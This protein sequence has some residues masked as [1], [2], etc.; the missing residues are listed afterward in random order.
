MSK[1]GK[2]VLFYIRNNK[3]SSLF[4]HNF[5]LI[6]I[7]V[8]LPAGLLCGAVFLYFRHAYLQEVDESAQN[9]LLQVQVS[10][11]ANQRNM[12]ALGRNMAN[13]SEISSFLAS[14]Y[15]NG[16]TFEE[17]QLLK[18]IWDDISRMKSEYVEE[19]AVFSMSNGYVIIG[20]G[21][22]MKQEYL[23]DAPDL[24]MVSN[25]LEDIS[26][27]TW[28]RVK[29]GAVGSNKGFLSTSIRVPLSQRGEIEGCIVLDMSGNWI[30]R[31]AQRDT[32]GYQNFFILNE[33]GTVLY[34]KDTEMTGHMLQEKYH[35]PEDYLKKSSERITGISESGKKILVNTVFSP[36]TK[37]YYVYFTGMENYYERIGKL[38]VALLI[39]L[40]ILA[41]VTM[42]V[43]YNVSVRVFLP[44][45]SVLEMVEDPKEF[46]EHNAGKE[47]EGG[48]RSEIKYLT[49]SFLSQ[50]SEQ[51]RVKEELADYMV[52][53]KQAQI[54][55][56]QTQI[57]PHFL[58]NTLQTLN[59]MSVALTRSE[60][61]VSHGIEMMCGMLREMMEVDR[62]LIRVEE[63]CAY[64]KAY[65]AL[66]QLRYQNEFE[67]DWQIPQELNEFLIVK[68]SI[69]PL[70]ENC[71]RHGF[72]EKRDNEKIIVSGRL[73]G[74]RLIFSVKDN[75]QGCPIERIREMN[76][77]L[78]D[79]TVIRGKHIGIRNVN[80]RIRLLFGKDY[81]LRIGEKAEGF[82]IFMEI[83]AVRE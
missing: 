6:F 3:F 2:D 5:L 71:I 34:H 37:W 82:E 41:G 63:E 36:S 70:L 72:R 13:S 81:G 27:S 54:A 24:D 39:A 50:I 42:A 1:A 46:Y 4:L 47:A 74:E 14:D 21:G 30:E 73:A 12:E 10:I 28:Y 19:I 65:I 8:L 23:R 60:N 57:N 75:G 22:I 26:H 33:E 53:L 48:T 80:Q 16:F 67:V 25:R 17:A 78:Q 58:F 69:Q 7:A 52:R 62:N 32:E 55:L 43:A 9:A 49:S 31:T 79:Y 15:T 68:I 56:L 83:P 59:F 64:G 77:E 20:S 38:T 61:D 76:R 45:R 40:I 35:L 66:E 44:L 11:D 51:E 29:E 18:N